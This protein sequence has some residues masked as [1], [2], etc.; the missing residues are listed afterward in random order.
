MRSRPGND[1]MFGIRDS[2]EKEWEWEGVESHYQNART[3]RHGKRTG[4]WF[5]TDAAQFHSEKLKVNL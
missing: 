1:G 4:G 2:D 3:M 5:A